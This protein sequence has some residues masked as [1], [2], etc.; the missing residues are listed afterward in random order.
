MS[1][2]KKQA[3]TAAILIV[4]LIA[5]DQVIKV[6][7]KLNMNLGESIHIFDWFQIEFIENVGMA[8]GMELG[9]KLFLSLFRII[10]IVFL[11]W[12]ITDRIRQGARTGY[13]VVL[14]MITAGAAGNIFDS[15]FY[16]QIFTASAPYYIEG[17]TPATLVPWGEGYA[18]VLMGKVVDMLYFPLFHGTFPDWI[19]LWGGESFV[20][21]SP[22]FNFADS[23]ISIGVMTIL[24]A[25]RKDF[26]GW[27]PAG[28]RP[29]A[30]NKAA[31]ADRDGCRQSEQCR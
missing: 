27:V 18:P 9:S 12:Y 6:A 24:L 28:S 22:V 7:V 20:F 13:I 29:V 26:N 25:F 10:A 16:G 17:A 14:A 2:Q 23:C 31:A 3:L 21:F 1:K 11:V 4:L 5:I 8:W 30:D 19:P 15:I